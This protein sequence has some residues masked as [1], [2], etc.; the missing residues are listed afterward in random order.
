MIEPVS[1]ALTTSI[2]PAVRAKKAMMSSAMLPKVA[3]RM[4]PICGPG[5]RAQTLGGGADDVGQAQDAQ[6]R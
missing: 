5:Q 1:D 2:C 3:L 4:P 6:R